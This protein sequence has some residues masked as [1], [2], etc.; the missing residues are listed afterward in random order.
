MVTG[1]S[2]VKLRIEECT[3]VDLYT[4]A[5]KEAMEDLYW[6]VEDRVFDFNK[7]EEIGEIRSTIGQE[8][9][10]F[11]IALDKKSEKPVG[12]VDFNLRNEVAFLRRWEPGVPAGLRASEVAKELMKEA[13]KLAKNRGARRMRVLLKHPYGS[14]EIAEWHLGI[15]R[16]S[17]FK[18]IG[19]PNVDLTMRLAKAI[20]PVEPKARFEVMTG[21]QITPEETAEYIIRA[22]ASKPE[23]A[24]LFEDDTS[25]TDPEQALRFAENVVAGHY[26]DSPNEFRRVLLIDGE[27]ACIVGAFAIDSAFKPLTGVLGPVGTFPEYRNQ[28]FG[29]FLV[30]QTLEALR[31][32]GCE[33]AA[34]GTGEANTRAIA[35]YEKV[36]FRLACQLRWFELKL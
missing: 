18:P 21:E 36:G 26:G 28:W 12:V 20:R 30:E 14:P 33:Y 32:Y 6:F 25:V 11:V 27:P 4:E 23:D 1:Y 9:S 2:S 22:Y 35:L 5:W 24:L 17:G 19:L 34:V 15:Y 3:D 16:D 7:D 8:E 31:M 29:R 13:R 10:V